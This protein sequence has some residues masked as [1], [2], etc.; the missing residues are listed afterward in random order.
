MKRFIS[1]KYKLFENL[2]LKMHFKHN[3]RLIATQYPAILH[4]ELLLQRNKLRNKYLNSLNCKIV[5]KNSYISWYN[6]FTW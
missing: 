5:I 1:W 4:D 3:M 6:H 2:E